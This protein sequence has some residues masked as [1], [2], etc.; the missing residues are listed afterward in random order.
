MNDLEK[1]L[2]DERRTVLAEERRHREMHELHQALID[3]F[4]QMK[5]RSSNFGQKRDGLD[6]ALAKEENVQK[7]HNR[8][9]LERRKKEGN[10]WMPL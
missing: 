1:G 6:G 2:L 9:D 8:I 4:A 7:G 10:Y 3:D 5:A